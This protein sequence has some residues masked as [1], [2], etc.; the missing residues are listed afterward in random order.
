MAEDLFVQAEFLIPI[1][2]DA[3][4]SDGRKHKLVVWEWL[5]DQLFREFGGAT[6]APGLYE[7]F[8]RDPDTGTRVHDQSRKL[9]VAVPRSRVDDLRSLLQQAAVLFQQKC[10]YFNIAGEVEFITPL[11]KE[12]R[13]DESEPDELP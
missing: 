9:I 4:L 12:G 3:L 7:G 10:L 6:R 8:Y 11:A 1:T 5:D 13:S 2:R